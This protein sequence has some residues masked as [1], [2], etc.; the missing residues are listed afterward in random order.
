MKLSP[1]LLAAALIAPPVQAQTA[2]SADDARAAIAAVLAHQTSMRG[3]ESAALI[4]VVA[5][6][7]PPPAAAGE[8]N[9]MMPPQSVRIYFQ[10]HVPE[11]PPIVRPPPQFRP[12]GRRQR[13]ER[14]PPVALP[15]AVPAELAGQLDALRAE[16]ARAT[17]APA[18]A[19]VDAALV[20][21]P[22]QLQGERDRGC[23]PLQL[24]VP[25]FAGDAAFVE[26]AYACGTTCGNGNLYA[27]R[28]REGRWEVVAVADTWIS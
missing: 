17:A 23:A 21:A 14:A 19:E 8:E 11:G 22:M 28:R 12:D 24:S 20:A 1:L 13:R 4:C 27:L 26:T 6:L 2:A 15:A 25:A 9:P 5:A 10:W 16:A 7:G 18:I 3:S